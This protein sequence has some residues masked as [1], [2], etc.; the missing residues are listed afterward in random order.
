MRKTSLKAEKDGIYR[1][2]IGYLRRVDDKLTQPKLGLGRV[3][4]MPRAHL[5]IATIWHRIELESKQAGTSPIWD[6]LS[7]MIAKAIARAVPPSGTASPTPTRKPTPELSKP[8]LRATPRS[9]FYL[10]TR[11]HTTR[12][13]QAKRKW[14]EAEAREKSLLALAPT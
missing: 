6:D 9:P 7:L 5:G 1:R 2:N 4:R 11:W 13:R 14:K 12:V 3:K 10:R 8:L